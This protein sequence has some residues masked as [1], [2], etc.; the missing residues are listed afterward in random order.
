M[1]ALASCIRVLRVS[2]RSSFRFFRHRGA[3]GGRQKQYQLRSATFECWK[4]FATE[5]SRSCGLSVTPISGQVTMCKYFDWFL[6]RGISL[7]VAQL[8]VV[9]IES[10]LRRVCG[11]FNKFRALQDLIRSHGCLRRTSA[12]HFWSLAVVKKRDIDIQL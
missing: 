5:I 9:T 11:Q 2:I 12:L 10:I 6:V 7:P 8:F 3:I 4:C 1:N